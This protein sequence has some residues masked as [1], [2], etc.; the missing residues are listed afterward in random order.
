MHFQMFEEKWQEHPPTSVAVLEKLRNKI[1]NAYNTD[2]DEILDY[3]EDS[4]IGRY[5]KMIHADLLYL[6]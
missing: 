3:I 4:Y 2:A 1:R 6:Q 5:R